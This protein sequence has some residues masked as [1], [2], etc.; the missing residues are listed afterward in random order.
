M[1]ANGSPLSGVTI[2]VKDTNVAVTSNQNGLFTL[3]APQ[4]AVLVISS[5]GYQRQEIAVE[6]RKTIN[7]T[8]SSSDQE[9]D[10]VVVTA[11]GIQRSERS[12]GYAAQKVKAETLTANKQN[13]VVNALQGKVAGVTISS[14]GGAPGQGANIQIEELILLTQ[15]E[16][17]IPYSLSMGPNGQFDFDN[18]KPSHRK[19][20]QQP[21]CR[22]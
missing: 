19:R 1:D 21:R 11:L 3:N 4:N 5:I 14:T 9:I 6:G 7:I 18:R 12:L 16:I 8:L 15:T 17:I 13:N 20:D 22:Y 10:E 2:S